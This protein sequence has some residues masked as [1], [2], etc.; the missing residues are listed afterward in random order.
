MLCI[1]FMFNPKLKKKGLKEKEEEKK[2]GKL[3]ITFL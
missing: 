3:Q 1:T 2:N